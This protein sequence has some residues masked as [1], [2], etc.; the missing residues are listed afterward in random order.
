MTTYPE[1]TLAAIQAAPVHFNRAA[2]TEKACGARACGNVEPNYL[3]GPPY[4]GTMRRRMSVVLGVLALC[5]MT[6]ATAP[7]SVGQPAAVVY[8]GHDIPKES[9]GH[10]HRTWSL[11]LVCNPA[12]LLR[13]NDEGIAKLFYVF[14]VFGSAIGP[15][16]LAVWFQRTPPSGGLGRTHPKEY[17][18][19]PDGRIL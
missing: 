5:S 6:F 12:W 14:W 9:F 8:T 10:P 1:F 11:F 7:H 17:R 18:S 3:T 15:D 16:N 13:N 4:K 2:S 19:R